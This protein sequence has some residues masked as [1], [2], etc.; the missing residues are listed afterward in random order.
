MEALNSL[1]LLLNEPLVQFF[2]WVAVLYII[3]AIFVDRRVSFWISSI[4]ATYFWVKT[5]DP[6]VALRAWFVVLA[7]FTVVLIA[8]YLFHM[9]I[10]LFLKGKKRCPM[11][12]EEAYRKAKVCPHCHYSF[13]SESD[14]CRED[15]F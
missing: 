2:L 11:C 3:A 9:N 4:S 1:L 6:A 12:C 8:R 15:K 7:V 14:E 10:V 13:T 5:Q